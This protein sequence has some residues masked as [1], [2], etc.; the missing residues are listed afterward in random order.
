MRKCYEVYSRTKTDLAYCGIKSDVVQTRSCSRPC[1]RHLQMDFKWK[2]SPWSQVS[3]FVMLKNIFENKQE[4]FI[5]KV[6]GKM[7]YWL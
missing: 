2:T 1:T 6:L 3:L 7:R 5:F 4:I